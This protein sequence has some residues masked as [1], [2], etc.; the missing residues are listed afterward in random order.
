MEYFANNLKIAALLEKLET[1]E[2]RISTRKR[3]YLFPG[4]EITSTTN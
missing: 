3:E 1:L 2:S 4:K